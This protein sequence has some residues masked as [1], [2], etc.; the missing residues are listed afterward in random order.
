MLELVALITQHIDNQQIKHDA[1]LVL[2]LLHDI[3]RKLD[4]RVLIKVDEELLLT[5]GRCASTHL[6]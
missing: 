5:R 4:P 1:P 6:L 2:E 3:Y